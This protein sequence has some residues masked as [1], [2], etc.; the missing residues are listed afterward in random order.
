MRSGSVGGERS[1]A[2]ERACVGDRAM[3]SVGRLFG[4]R[5]TQRRRRG[6]V[7]LIPNWQLALLT[8]VPPAPEPPMKFPTRRKQEIVRAYVLATG[9]RLPTDLDAL[10]AAMRSHI[11]DLSDAEVR[12]AI[13]WSLRRSR[14]A[15]AALERKLGY[16]LRDD[17][18]AC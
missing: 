14:R 4:G 6:V 17:A 15:G 18:L 8:A 9:G 2:L 7:T 10:L 13:A 12:C 16:G 5:R 11:G 1:V 3:V